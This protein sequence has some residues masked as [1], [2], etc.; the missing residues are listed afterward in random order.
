[1][2]PDQLSQLRECPNCGDDDM[3]EIEYMD[4]FSFGYVSG[5][6]CMLCDA[7]GSDPVLQHQIEH[8]QRLIA[9]ARQKT[10]EQN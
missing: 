9:A 6:R 8:N 10:S 1:M 7:C 3:R 4:A 2:T 5:L